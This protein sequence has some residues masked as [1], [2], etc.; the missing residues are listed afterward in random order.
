MAVGMVAELPDMLVLEDKGLAV[1][2]PR[3][4]LVA[5]TSELAMSLAVE[6]KGAVVRFAHQ[7]VAESVG[8]AELAQALVPLSEV[9]PA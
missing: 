4:A 5:D 9:R 7:E 2:E 6:D 8:P 3:Q 1:V